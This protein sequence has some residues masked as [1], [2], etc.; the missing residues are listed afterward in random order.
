MRELRVSERGRTQLLS[1]LV[2][3]DGASIT[4]IIDN[5]EREQ[6]FIGNPD[7][8]WHSIK[9]KDYSKFSNFF[10]LLTKVAAELTNTKESMKNT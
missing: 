7:E 2:V 10:N 5:L 6:N 9:K 8:C 4:T 1:T 3:T